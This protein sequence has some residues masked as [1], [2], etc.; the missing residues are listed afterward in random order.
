MESALWRWAR[1]L[2]GAGE[3]QSDEEALSEVLSLWCVIPPP[4]HL[5]AVFHSMSD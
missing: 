5:S 3:Q 2:S 4:H 1:G